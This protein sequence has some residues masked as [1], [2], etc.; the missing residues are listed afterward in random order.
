MGGT[1]V[2]FFL[3]L[4][5]FASLAISSAFQSDELIADDEE[6]GLEGERTPNR[7]I[8]FSVRSPPR[9]KT[10]G[11]LSASTDVKSVQFNLEHAFG[12]S[13]FSPAG[14]FT[15]RLKSSNHGGQ[16][17]LILGSCGFLFN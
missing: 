8:P 3:L 11:D 2:R 7:E 14:I 13:D 4:G 1:P 5:I 16:V 10:G 6:F 15:A 9:A 12:D 17:Y